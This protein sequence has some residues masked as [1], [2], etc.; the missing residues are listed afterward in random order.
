MA[1]DD[2]FKH[3]PSC[4]KIG[5]GRMGVV[6]EADNTVSGRFV[7]LKLLPGKLANNSGAAGAFP[8]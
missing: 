1:K 2:R 8:A 4:G 3:L 7:A 5:G 6:Y